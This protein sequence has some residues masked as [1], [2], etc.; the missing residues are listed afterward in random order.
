MPDLRGMPKR[1]LLPL[2]SRT[3]ISVEISG[4]GRV[5]EQEPAPG[6]PVPPGTVVRLVL[7]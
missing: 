7:E 2:L 4:E 5:A 6:D 1:S 3:D